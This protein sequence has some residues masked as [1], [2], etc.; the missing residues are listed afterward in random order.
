MQKKLENS[1]ED[2]IKLKNKIIEENMSNTN[3]INIKDVNIIK[4][5]IK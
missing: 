2:I 4:Y 3:I 1:D 5:L